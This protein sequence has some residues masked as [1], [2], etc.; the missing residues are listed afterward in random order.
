MKPFHSLI[1]DSLA[2]TKLVDVYIELRNHFQELGFSESDLNNPPTYTA[3]MLNLHDKF[4]DRL[5]SLQQTIRDYGFDVTKEEVIEYIK[6]I[7]MKINEITP[8]KNGDN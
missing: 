3:K 4:S 2:L 7:L 6:P 8:L 5:K 1:E